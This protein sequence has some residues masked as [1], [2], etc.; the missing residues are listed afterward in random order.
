M[1]YL[2]ITTAALVT[3]SFI[4]IWIYKSWTN[5]KIQL[6]TLITSSI[7]IGMLPTAITF[8]VSP[9]YPKL[10]IS[11]PDLGLWIVI[12][13]LVLLFIGTNSLLRN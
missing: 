2:N 10:S 13:G 7:R 8:I 11:I 1:T 6:D 12:T 4:G 3:L 5:Q 9:F